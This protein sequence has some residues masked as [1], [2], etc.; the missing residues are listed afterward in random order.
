MDSLDNINAVERMQS[1]IEAHLNGPITLHMLANAAGYSPWHA[2]KLFKALTGKSPFEYIRAVRLSRAAIKLRDEDVKIVDVAFDFVFDSHEGFTRAFSKQFGITPRSFSQNKPP[3]KLFIPNNVHEIYLALQ[4]GDYKMAETLK[5][6][7]IFVQVVDRP[8]RMLIMKRGIKAAD[9]YAY[10][11]EVGCEVWDVLSGIK[12]ALYE[13]IGMW[14]PENLR[15]PGTSLYAQGVEMPA[16]Y[17]GPIPEGFD[18]IDLLPCKM[19]IFQ[20]QPYDDANFEE[21]I[22]G[23]WETIKNYKPE[24]YGFKWADEDGPRFQLEPQGYRGYIEGRAVRQLRE[25]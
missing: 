18:C 11:E 3:I 12:Q 14:L 24:I 15:K 23:L 25:V 9:Y 10:C 20:G 5:T 2:A 13:P 8:S 1:Y 16:D 17:S 19:M 22:G 6:N 21:A 7:V 4:K